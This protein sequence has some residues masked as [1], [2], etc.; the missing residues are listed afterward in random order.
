MSQCLLKGLVESVRLELE[1]EKRMGYVSSTVRQCDT[2]AYKINKQ[3]AKIVLCSPQSGR[4]S[5]RGHAIEF[6]VTLFHKI[7]QEACRLL[8]SV[9]RKLF[10]VHRVRFEKTSKSC[11]CWNN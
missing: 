1:I 10:I 4:A 8:S 9:H 11:G 6:T 3:H 2:T 7:S 5:E